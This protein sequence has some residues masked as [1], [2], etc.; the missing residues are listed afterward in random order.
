MRTSGRAGAMITAA[1]A[2]WDLGRTPSKAQHSTTRPWRAVAGRLGR[3]AAWA[4]LP[5][6]GEC[7]DS[8]NGRAAEPDESRARP[9]PRCSRFPPAGAFP[10]VRDVALIGRGTRPYVNRLRLDRYDEKDFT[11]LVKAMTSD[12]LW[13]L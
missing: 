3:R 2:A 1:L 4:R 9:S 12:G 13:M 11:T 7:R 10:P 6:R 8:A 5:G